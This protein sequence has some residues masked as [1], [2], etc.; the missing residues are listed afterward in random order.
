[1]TFEEML[2]ENRLRLLASEVKREADQRQSAIDTLESAA[3]YCRKRLDE[4]AKAD[5]IRWDA[6]AKQYTSKWSAGYADAYM[7]IGQL[8]WDQFPE[9]RN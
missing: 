3:R 4:E 2:A 5:K 6:G 7:L 8:L 9:W 1:M